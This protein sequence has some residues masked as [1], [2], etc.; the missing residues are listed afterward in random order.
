MTMSQAGAPPAGTADPRRW[1]ALA[2]VLAAVFMDLVDITIVLVAAPA[3]QADLG[4][5]YAGIQWVIAAY[6]LSLGLLLITGGRLG[7]IVGRKRIFLAGVATFTAASA[8]CGLAPSIE[9]LIAARA[10]QGAAAALMVP[11]VLAT[12]QVAFAPGERPKAYGVYGAVNG[13]AAAAAPIVGGVLV[14]NNVFEL[15]WRSVFWVNVPIGVVTVIGAALLMR[16]TRSP[17]RPRLDVPGVLLVT[18][19]LLLLLYPL[20]Q[21]NDLG[22]PAWAWVMM[23][24][25]LG[26]LVAF[27]RHQS[28]RERRDAIDPAR[29]PGQPLVPMSLFRQRSFTA[30]IVT[31]IVMFSSVSSLFLVLTIQLQ[32]GHHFSAL[33]VGLAFLAWPVGLAATSGVAVKLATRVGRRL[34]SVGA[35]LLAL[36]MTSLIVTIRAV[37]E[38]LSG[39]H[40]VPGLLMGGLGFGLVAPIL[41]DIVLSAVPPGDAG[42]ASGVTNTA[43]QVSGAAGIAI[44]GSLFSSFLAADGDF[45]LAAQRALWYPVAAFAAGVVLSRALPSRARPAGIAPIDSATDPRSATS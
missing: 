35:A 15:G 34:V 38:G 27:G 13:L 7:D 6:A 3:I 2:V 43:I 16:E 25:S 4:A 30:G 20:I 42:A 1:A 18:S 32:S 39:W 19:G 41:V 24:S 33:S 23:G 12:I 31:V 45:D 10:V 26:V 40:L 17:E 28:A 37:G 14:S 44:V 36:A 22:W 5:G 8:T 29:H 9:V 11:Q 21:G